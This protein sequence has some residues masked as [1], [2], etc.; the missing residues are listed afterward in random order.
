MKTIEINKTNWIFRFVCAVWKTDEKSFKGFCPFFYLSAFT[1]VL[2][3]LSL[4][5]LVVFNCIEWY[6]EYDSKT[7]AQRY[8]WAEGYYRWIESDSN[9]KA[10][11][12]ANFCKSKQLLRFYKDYLY[13]FNPRLYRICADIHSIYLNEKRE[14]STNRVN[15]VYKHISPIAN[16]IFIIVISM[17]ALQAL[18]LVYLII[19]WLSHVPNADWKQFFKII[20]QV[21]GFIL[22]V[23]VAL[24]FLIKKVVIKYVP[25]SWNHCYSFIMMI[26]DKYC[27]LIIWK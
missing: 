24:F 27:P 23:G 8:L 25:I 19:Q 15:K 2:L 22:V 13:E 26:F 7:L 10:Y 1:I 5:V 3:P 4:L 14:K 12:L 11:F 9:Q 16:V 18:Y 17:A 6:N 20:F 21:L